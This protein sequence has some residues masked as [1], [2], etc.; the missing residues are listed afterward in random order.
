MV[1]RSCVVTLLHNSGVMRKFPSFPA[2]A[3]TISGPSWR[4]WRRKDGAFCHGVERRSLTTLR[5]SVDRSRTRLR[6]VPVILVVV[7]PFASFFTLC[8]DFIASSAPQRELRKREHHPSGVN[9]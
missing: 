5:A 1:P 8:S 7:N 2:G 4:W 9:S 3:V 6:F